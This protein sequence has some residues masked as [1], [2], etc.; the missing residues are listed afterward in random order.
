VHE[1]GNGTDVDELSR[2]LR[3]ESKCAFLVADVSN[4]RLRHLDRTLR[5]MRWRRGIL[6]WSGSEIEELRCPEAHY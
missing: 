1:A 2:L 4:R 3:T 6:F 5:R